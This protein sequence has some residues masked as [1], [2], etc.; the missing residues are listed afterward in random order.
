MNAR[1]RVLV[2]DDERL[3]RDLIEAILSPDGYEVRAAV[4]GPSALSQVSGALT[5]CPS[6]SM[7]S[8]G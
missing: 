5:E 2:V 6:F 3:N 7:R 8:G 1:P 4:D